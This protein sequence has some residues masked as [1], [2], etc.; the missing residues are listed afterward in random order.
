MLH[1]L[2]I[3]LLLGLLVWAVGRNNGG[4]DLSKT[5]KSRLGGT[6]GGRRALRAFMRQRRRG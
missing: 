3:F 1:L 2:V 4:K 5:G 6:A